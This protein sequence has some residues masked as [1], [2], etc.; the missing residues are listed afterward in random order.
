MDVGLKLTQATL[1][2]Q[3]LSASV[4]SIGE[5][6]FKSCVVKSPENLP[7]GGVPVLFP[8][9]ADRGA[10]SKHGFARH[11]HWSSGVQTEASTHWYSLKSLEIQADDFSAWQHSAK[12]VLETHFGQSSFRQD[13]TVTNTG[14]DSFMWSGGLHPYFLVE[15]LQTSSLSGL[16]G[17]AYKDHYSEESDLIGE[18]HLVWDKHPC[19]KLFG[20]APPLLLSRG[21]KELRIST[22][23][24]DQWMI[25]NPG[26]S[27]ASELAD[28]ED[29]DWQRF[30]CIE[31]VCVDKP[32]ML[33]PEATFSGSMKIEW[34]I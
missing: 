23:G 4:P 13:L 7:R 15:N 6:F 12:L 1:G 28:M 26:K 29:G 21:S 10:L 3:V 27:G 9:F 5:L 31:P 22:T 20:A 30:V 8:Q 17:V 25:W 33:M 16:D 34:D 19:E 32:V 18:S 24:F 11:S 14:S 2:A